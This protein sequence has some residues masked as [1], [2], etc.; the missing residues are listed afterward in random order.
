MIDHWMGDSL[1]IIYQ[2][3]LLWLKKDML[4]SDILKNRHLLPIVCILKYSFFVIEMQ[5]LCY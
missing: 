1:E 3:H 5:P 2:V 4:F